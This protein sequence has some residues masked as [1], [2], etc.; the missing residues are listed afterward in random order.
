MRMYHVGKY[1][2]AKSV[3]NRRQVRS[4]PKKI[5]LQK[6]LHGTQTLHGSRVESENAANARREAC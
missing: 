3:A 1:L 2:L 6:R 5:V 4:L